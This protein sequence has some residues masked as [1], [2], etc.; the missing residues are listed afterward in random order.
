MPK[1]TIGYRP[2]TVADLAQAMEIEREAFAS[3]WPEEGFRQELSHDGVSFFL[4]GFDG[5]ELAGYAGYQ[6]V[7]DEMHIT[8]IA[9]SE[10]YRRTGIGREL[11]R[12][13]LQDGLARGALR[14]QLE[15]RRSNLTA[16]RLYRS[17]GFEETGVRL[18]YYRDEKEDAIL[19]D[20]SIEKE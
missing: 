9:V 16:R 12:R 18:D 14:A 11:T 20:I 4:A 7:L 2:M 6:L 10:R 13:L 3:P 19:M 1:R 15:V 17:F 8:N 5:L